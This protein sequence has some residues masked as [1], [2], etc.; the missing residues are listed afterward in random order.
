[1]LASFEWSPEAKVVSLACYP[2]GIH[3]PIKSFVLAK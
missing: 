2:E 3:S 1:V